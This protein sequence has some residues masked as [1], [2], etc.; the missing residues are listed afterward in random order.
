MRAVGPRKFTLSLPS[1]KTV[2]AQLRVPAT[3]Q[4][5]CWYLVRSA[6]QL[7]L[8]TWLLSLHPVTEGVLQRHGS[9]TVLEHNTAS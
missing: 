1:C 5:C 7:G 8:T 6:L 9:L 3:V 4:E 2:S